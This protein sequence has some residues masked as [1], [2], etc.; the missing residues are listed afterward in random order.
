MCHRLSDIDRRPILPLCRKVVCLACDQVGIGR[1]MVSVKEGEEQSPLTMMGFAFRVKDALTEDARFGG[2]DRSL[3]IV[4][5]IRHQHMPDIGGMVQHI[6]G[7]ITLPQEQFD[8]KTHRELDHV[9]IGVTTQE[10]T[11]GVTTK[12]G[13]TSPPARDRWTG[14][15]WC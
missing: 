8:D 5:L 13:E 4:V 15:D 11:E 3:P 9:A 12:F 6:H 14:K 1:D 10:K 7:G 2:G